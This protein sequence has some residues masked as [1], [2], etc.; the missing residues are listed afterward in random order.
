MQD[1]SVIQPTGYIDEDRE[2]I[3]NNFAAIISDFSDTSFP[4]NNRIAGMWC[5]RTDQQKIYRLA[6]DLVTWKVVLDYSSGT[7]TVPQA[8]YATGA[9]AALNDNSGQE[10]TTT[11]VR[12]VQNSGSVLT[13]TKGDGTSTKL[14]MPNTTYNVMGGASTTL[15][16][17]AGLVPAPSAGQSTRY[18]RSDG[19]WVVPPND[20]T[21]Y[22]VMTG[23]TSSAAGAAGLVPAP[24][25]G[26]NSKFLRGDGTFQTISIA[27]S[28]IASTTFTA[29]TQGTRALYGIGCSGGVDS[30]TT[31]GS[32]DIKSSSI[33]LHVTPAFRAGTYTLKNAIQACINATHKHTIEINTKYSNCNCDCGDDCGG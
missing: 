24:S 28:A 20:N 14:T 22:S 29:S 18:L 9:K 32:G 2:K 12:N 16:G 17:S 25:A 33:I 23:A 15:A 31:S 3:N 19:T 27:E 5:D 7:F 26:A 13:I 10:I 30:N 11:Y 4:T 1:F 21:T 6:D 8:D